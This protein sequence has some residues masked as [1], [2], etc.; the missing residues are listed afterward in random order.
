M[1]CRLSANVQLLA[2]CDHLMKIS[3]ANFRPPPK[4]ESSIVRIEPRNPQPDINFVEWDGLLR[5]CFSRKN[6]TLNAVFKSKSVIKLLYQNYLLILEQQKQALLEKNDKI[7][8]Q[9]ATSKLQLED[10]ARAKE[11][12][13]IDALNNLAENEEET[14]PKNAGKQNNKE[15]DNEDDDEEDEEEIDNAAERKKLK[16]KKKQRGK[17]K[18]KAWNIDDGRLVDDDEKDNDDEDDKNELNGIELKEGAL[19]FKD[20]IMNVLE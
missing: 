14:K 13:L 4:V 8:I 5:I 10:Q 18:N 3:K 1:Y 11:Q 17:G 6:K 2:K 16:R 12:M 19:K 15:S 9:H 20:V 7:N